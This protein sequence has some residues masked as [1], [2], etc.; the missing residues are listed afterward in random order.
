[1]ILIAVGASH[2]LGLS[3]LIATMTLGATLINLEKESRRLFAV[4]S[5]T[6]PPLYAIFFVLA[7]AHLQLS[8]LLL[9]GISGMGY[10]LSRVAGKMAG[11]WY[12][13][14]KLGYPEIV[15]KYLGV[16]LVAHGGV[17]IGLALQVRSIFPKYEGVI[18]TVILGSVLINEVL[19]PMLTKFA[20]ARAGEARFEHAGVIEEI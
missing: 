19:G 1:M 16:T 18:A 7:G 8:S 12:G 10:T 17:A 15:S 4:L 9:I 11:A 6:D 13:A 5:K 3:S 14:K 20:L 2:W